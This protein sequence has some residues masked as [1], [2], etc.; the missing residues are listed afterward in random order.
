[1]EYLASESLSAAVAE[2]GPLPPIEV[3]RIGTEIASALA[4]AHTAG[5]VHRDIKPGNV[6]LGERAA[7]ITDFGISRAV[8]ELTLTATGVLAGTPAYLAP[9]V[10]RGEPADYRSDAFSFGSTLYTAVE[11]VPP[12]GRSENPIAMLH[13]VASGDVRPPTNAGAMSPLLL[14][15]LDVSPERRPTM[16]EAARMLAALAG[17]PGQVPPLEPVTVRIE[18]PALAEP[19]PLTPAP[20]MVPV[21]PVVPPARPENRR[22][23]RPVLIGL[24]VAVA[25]VAAAIIGVLALVDFDRRNVA[26]PGPGPT[27]QQPAPSVTA[28]PEPTAP[29]TPS[30]TAATSTAAQGLADYYALLPDDL[31]AGY[32]RLSDRFKRDRSPTFGGYAQ[33]FGQFRSIST[34]DV[35]ER[36][37]GS[38]SARITYV[39]E[40][41]ERETERHVYTLE[42]Q[43]GV[44]VIDSQRSAD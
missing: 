33:F 22:N 19:T 36:D 39:R 38:V 17:S 18:Q 2:R 29:S 30:T 13:R 31:R 1:M 7:K 10:A 20:R 6:L 37:D 21:E 34:S 44:W 25:V 35:R 9:E 43:D 41:G 4:A 26:G 11:G 15:L 28:S 5:I 24:V 12:F 23:R 27:Q 40:N 32:D 16:A 14:R 42:L 8:G 3:A